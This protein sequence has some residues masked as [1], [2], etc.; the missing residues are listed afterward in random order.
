MGQLYDSGLGV[1]KDSAQAKM[2]YQKS[3]DAGNPDAKKW[4]AAHGG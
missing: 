2:W 3:A 1:A 4:L